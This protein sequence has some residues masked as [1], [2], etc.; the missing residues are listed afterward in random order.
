MVLQLSELLRYVIYD[1]QLNKVM[2]RKEVAQIKRFIELFQ[3]R[4][5]Q[6]PDI[7]FQYQ[8]LPPDISIEPM[9][10]IPLVENCFKH[11]DFDTNATAFVKISLRVHK[12]QL[13]FETL[14]SKHDALQQKDKIGG[15]GLENI[16]QR[17][18]LKY[19]KR[20]E[21]RV[22]NELDRFRVSMKLMLQQNN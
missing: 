10:P 4:S 7:S 1:S 9:M 19:P 5:E 6:T 16:R 15:V 13:E 8:D 21:M 22:E 20:H 12:N 11:G 2:L 17:L 3:M 14:N 18:A